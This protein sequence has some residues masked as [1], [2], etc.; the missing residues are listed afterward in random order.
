MKGISNLML[1][2]FPCA[3]SGEGALLH[4]N[5]S[6]GY[7]VWH[8]TSLI[9]WFRTGGHTVSLQEVSE[10]AEGALGK[11]GEGLEALERT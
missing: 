10:G 5:E 9:L 2:V 7:W 8:C 1:V 4:P 6:E 3:C 11:C